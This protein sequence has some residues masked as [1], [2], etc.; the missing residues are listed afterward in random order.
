MRQLLLISSS[1]TYGS[2]FLEHAAEAIQ[3][4]L[5]D[6]SRVLFVP[7]ALFNRDAY[8]RLAAK[9]FR[10]IGFEMDS[11]HTLDDPVRAVQQAE[12]IFVGGGNTFRLLNSLY[13]M[14]LI[15]PIRDAV[16]GGAKYMGSSAG[17]NITCPTICTT[18][19]MPIVEPPTF[20][21]L[22]L[23]PFQINPH[24]LDADPHSR[25]QGES[26][27]ARIA[28]YLEENTRPVLGIREGSWLKIENDF[29]EL[30]GSNGAVLF[31]RDQSPR[32]LNSGES[33]SY[34]LN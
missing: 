21:A 7:F 16:A 1:R 23:I 30:Q 13:E 15:Q 9:S 24:Y 28:E 22:N 4:H 18:N 33:I 27:E 20:E 17:T 3:M 34:L 19:D 25:H 31:Q 5:G 8:A 12:A 29:G 10:D 6:T 26:R 11:L 32:Q 2:G 14:Q